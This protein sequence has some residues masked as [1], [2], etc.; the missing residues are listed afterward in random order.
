VLHGRIDDPG[1]RVEAMKAA[2]VI[3]AVGA[4]LATASPAAGQGGGLGEAS[5]AGRVTLAA[6]GKHAFTDARAERSVR[7]AMRRN[8]FTAIDAACIRAPRAK[9]ADCTVSATDDVLWT[10]TATVTRGT[11]SYRVEYFV[12]G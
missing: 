5:Q 2:G 3:L 8:G 10:G 1:S 7:K 6:T 4:V 9:V 12:S 11:K